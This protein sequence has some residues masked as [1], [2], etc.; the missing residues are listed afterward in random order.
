MAAVVGAGPAVRE[1]AE[2]AGVRLLEPGADLA[3]AMA[4]TDVDVLLSVA[5]RR[6]LPPATVAIARLAAVNFH[7]GPLPERSGLNVPGWSIL[8]D[9]RGYLWMSGNR[10]I[11][12]SFHGH[13]AIWDN[14]WHSLGHWGN[15]NH[16]YAFAEESSGAFWIGG[17]GGAA[18]YK[19]GFF[20][21][22]GRR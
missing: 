19:N 21:R 6:V 15:N 7:D 11:A 5:N 12:M 4:G 17:I 2:E 13:V 9:A 20:Q 1:W 8:E 16:T 3:A 18:R 22:K 14:G 10:G